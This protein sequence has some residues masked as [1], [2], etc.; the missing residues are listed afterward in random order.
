MD[1]FLILHFKLLLSSYSKKIISNMK[2]IFFLTITIAIFFISK[3]N[4]S[5]QWNECI[6]FGEAAFMDDVTEVVGGTGSTTSTNQY[7][8]LTGPDAFGNYTAGPDGTPDIQIDV[9]IMVDAEGNV[10]TPG[11]DCLTPTD[12]DD[13]ELVVT[14]GSGQINL[15]S[16][17]PGN[18]DVCECSDVWAAVTISFLGGL[19][20]D[21]QNLAINYTSTNGA[22]LMYESLQVTTNGMPYNTANITNYCGTDYHNALSMGDYLA[23]NPAGT[24]VYTGTPS[25]VPILGDAAGGQVQVGWWAVD[26]FNAPLEAGYDPAT[27]SFPTCNDPAADEDNGS[28]GGNGAVNDN[29]EIV[30]SAA[31]AGCGTGNPDEAD[32]SLGHAP[33]DVITSVTYLY[34]V[35][36]I[37]LDCNGDGTVGDNSSPQMN[38]QDLCIGFCP[39][40]TYPEPTITLVEDCGFFDIMIGTIDETMASGTGTSVT[41]TTAATAPTVMPG[42]P[43]TGAEQLPA[44]GSTMY[45]IQIADAADP[46]CIEEFGPFTAPAGTPGPMLTVTCPPPIDVCAATTTAP[47]GLTDSS[48]G[49]MAVYG[50]SCAVYV[51]DNGTANDVTDDFIDAAGAPVGS[52][53]LTIQLVDANGCDSGPN[54][55]VC[56]ILFE[57]NCD[58]DG[59]AFPTGP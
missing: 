47:L 1:F 35:A 30:G 52:C 51:N 3:Y 4:V 24:T 14:T 36:S 19:M 5:A 56:T 43:V 17:T 45:Y 39:P 59:G 42:T 2:R 40:C 15:N 29:Q 38:I 16:N 13:W 50:G 41:Y 33:T 32:G 49:A 58:A 53:M 44:D 22:S 6:S 21:A 48:G 55:E 10:T 34:N 11:A 46:T 25:F 9:E 27:M 23:G 20:V 18:Q 7:D 12:L 37:G 28:S 8:V 54:P 57:S 31:S 26:D